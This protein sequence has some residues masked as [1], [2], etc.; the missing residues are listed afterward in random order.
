M[1]SSTVRDNPHLRVPV[2]GLLGWLLPGAGHLFVGER[3]RGVIVMAAIAVTFWTGMAIGGVKSTVDPQQ[4]SLWFL[5]QI[6]AG[7]HALAAVWWSHHLD[8][9]RDEDPS[10]LIAYGRAEEV[11]VVYTA[12]CGMLNILVVLDVLARAERQPL[13]SSHRGPP[14]RR[15]GAQS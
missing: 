6:C 14:G 10:R 1:K 15:E 4:R 5:G 7:S 2:A 9:E 11:A 3:A 12:I 8:A 13:P